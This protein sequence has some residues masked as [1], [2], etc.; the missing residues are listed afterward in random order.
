MAYNNGFRVWNDGG[1]N[2]S[3]APRSY[4]GNGNWRR[5]SY[6]KSSCTTGIINTGK[7]KGM[8][9]I[10]GVL[11]GRSGTVIYMATPYKN[12]RTIKTPYGEKELWMVTI[13][14][15]MGKNT[16][17]CFVDVA[18]KTV[19]VPDAGVKFSPNS[20]YG[21]GGYCTYIKRKR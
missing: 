15:K 9:Y 12:T 10:C 21:Q 7:N 6:K 2:F 19:K 5:S 1:G 17:S 16:A 13:K 8:P 14:S 3:N 20:S 18:S 4:N 11:R